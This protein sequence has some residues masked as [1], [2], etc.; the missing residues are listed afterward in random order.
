MPLFNRL[1][2][3]KKKRAVLIGLDG[4][5]FTLLQRLMAEGVA[6]NLAKLAAAGPAHFQQMDAS[7][8]EISSVS[9]SSFMTG[10]NPA[11]HGIYGFMDLKPG[12]YQMYFPSYP[13]LKAAPLWDTLG[14]RGKR[15]VVLNLPGTYPAR[16]HEGVLVSGF[17]AIDL[18]KAVHPPQAL[19]A[20]E[21]MGYRIDVD[22]SRAQDAEFL[23]RDLD[24]TLAARERAFDHFW[25]EEAWDLFVAVITGTD[26]LQHFQWD[27]V[28]DPSH[29]NHERAMAFYRKAD[30][31][32]GRLVE[33]LSDGDALYVMSDHGFCGIQSEVY[34]NR[35]LVEKG[36]LAW[37]KD[38]PDSFADIAAESRAFVLDPSRV[39]LHRKGRYPK[40]T[41]EEGE[42]P[43]LRE[44]LKALFLSLEH[45]GRKVIQKVFFPEEIY[46]GPEFDRAPDL[47]LLTH[48]GFDLKGNIKRREV[49]GRTHFTGM[50]T[51]HDAFLLSNRPLPGKRPHIEDVH[52]LLL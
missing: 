3:K 34:L 17:V 35:L 43:A 48:D 6:P 51:R 45:G 9:W 40:G 36:Y 11:R 12:T 44:E 46:E 27:A 2:S 25:R 20:L 38:P 39:Y 42:A 37:E 28:E 22:T 18:K 33:R 50:H 32:V 4:V 15:S 31:V 21:K 14:R 7:L 19:P 16:P 23:Y 29:P 52:R 8:P 49:F 13:H 10:V 5:P 47:V 1:F 41:V 30:G 24:E 26:R